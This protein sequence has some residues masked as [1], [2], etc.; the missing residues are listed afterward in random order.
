MLAEAENRAMLAAQW[1]ARP[2]APGTVASLPTPARV[3]SLHHAAAEGRRTASGAPGVRRKTKETTTSSGTQVSGAHKRTAVV[4]MEQESQSDS[5]ETI[6]KGLAV[7][8]ALRPAVPTV[9]APPP[10]AAGGS[11]IPS[12]P[13]F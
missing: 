11:E 3:G 10:V 8:S 7:L 6:Q 9:E 1:P 13:S 2:L 4:D 5:D 12:D